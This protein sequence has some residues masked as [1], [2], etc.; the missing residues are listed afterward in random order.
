MSKI[1]YCT[2]EY[3][4]SKTLEYFINF[5]A[6]LEVC[7]IDKQEYCISFETEFEGYQFEKLN[8]KSRCKF[9]SKNYEN[10]Y[11]ILSLMGEKDTVKI[12]EIIQIILKAR[13]LPI[14]CIWTQSIQYILDLKD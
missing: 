12:N 4:S 5:K 9:C 11:E 14:E 3:T 2:I 7:P 10:I 6:P 1:I 13:Q 8:F